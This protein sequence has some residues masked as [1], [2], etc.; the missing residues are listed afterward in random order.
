MWWNCA[1]PGTR[2]GIWSSFW[3]SDGWNKELVRFDFQQPH[4][5]GQMDHTI[6]QVRRYPEVR[7]DVRFGY[8]AGLA[9]EGDILYIAS[10]GEGV[11]KAFKTDSAQFGSTAREAYPIFSSRLPSFDYALFMCADV[12]EFATGLAKPTG[13]AV[14][15]G[16]LF[17]R[18]TPSAFLSSSLRLVPILA[19]S[20]S[21]RT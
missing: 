4:G 18:L 7:I 5:P 20:T 3:Q 13:L 6:A 15:N 9:V 11:I 21:V 17:R 16:R 8:H 10:T 14:S 2:N 19:R 1:R 12:Q